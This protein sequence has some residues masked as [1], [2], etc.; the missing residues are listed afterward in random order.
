[1]TTHL[2]P[3]ALA[4][5]AVMY[6]LLHRSLLL[7][8]PMLL[9]A[10]VSCNGNDDPAT[11]QDPGSITGIVVDEEGEG[12]P[13]AGLLVSRSGED[14]RTATSGGDGTFSVASL[15]PGGWI[16]AVT[17]PSGYEAAPNQSLSLQVEVPSGDAVEVTI[18]LRSVDPGENDDVVEIQLTVSQTFSPDDVTIEPGTTVRWVNV[19]NELHTVTPDG[20]S[21]WARAE[22]SSS[23][24]TFEHTF[25]TEGVFDYFCEPHL[26]MGMT[27]T[28]RVESNAD[29]ND[30]D[31]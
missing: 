17:P 10:V 7:S 24:E 13:G 15:V 27:G 21:E 4:P 23:G 29:D 31:P 28:I 3:T 26:A 20:H 6:P 11:P 9:T 12:L 16:L 19:S 1:M 5:E 30:E 2:I 22:L 14:D 25:E 18:Q 8:L